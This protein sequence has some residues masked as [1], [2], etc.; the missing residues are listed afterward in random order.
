MTN[1]LSHFSKVSK[2]TPNSV[3]ISW[4]EGKLAEAASL[5]NYRVEFVKTGENEFKVQD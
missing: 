3:T 5:M 2:S 4:T 1:Y